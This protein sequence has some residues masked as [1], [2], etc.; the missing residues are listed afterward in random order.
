MLKVEK[1]EKISSFNEGELCLDFVNT[2]DWRFSEKRKKETLHDFFDVISWVKQEGILEDETVQKIII[3]ASKQL[4]KVNLIYKKTIELRELLHRIFS[5]IATTGQASTK[6]I[7]LFN[8]LLADSLGKSCC[9]TPSG[10][11]FVWAFSSAIDSIDLFLNPIIKSAADFLVSP[12]LK[13]LKQC[14]DEQCGWLFI[15]KS[16]NN[17]RRWCSMND[18]GNRAKAHR[19]YERKIQRKKI[20]NYKT[21]KT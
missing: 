17:S 4:D 13:R 18:C 15:D 10:N 20:R 9:V 7:S 5:S 12:N 2:V 11:G 16:R 21:G 3:T 1:C 8:H 19:H 6:N 14:A